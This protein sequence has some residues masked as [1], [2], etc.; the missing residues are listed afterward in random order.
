MAQSDKAIL[1]LGDDRYEFPLIVGSEGEKAIDISKLRARTGHVTLDPAFVNTA[2]CTSDITFLDGEQ[3]ILRYRGIPIE[4]LAEQ[5][6][7]TE[8]AYLLIYG[9]LPNHNELMAFRAQLSRHSMIHEGLKELIDRFPPGAHPMAILSSAVC[10]LSA[11][12]PELADMNQTAEEIELSMVRLIAKITT[13]AAY[14]YKQSIGHPLL[15][16][17]NSLGYCA[18]FLRMMFGV[19]CEPYE[20]D[21]ELVAAIRVL[22]ILHADH[23]QNCSTSTV[24]LVGSSRA[25]LFAAISAGILA[26]W[27]PLHGGANQAVL[28]MLEQIRAAGGD[29]KQFV[30]KAKDPDDS[31][32]L[33]GF[34][35]RVYKNYDPRAKIIKRTADTVLGKL[36]GDDELLDI[37]KELEAAALSDEYFVERKLY[38]NVDFYSGIIYHAMG[39]PTNMFTVMFAIG[40]LPGWIGQWKEML[41]QDSKIGRPRQI[42]TGATE[43]H[44]VPLDQR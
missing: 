42:Y 43:R 35:H 39:I 25:N 5:S 6:S 36:G 19:P 31:F 29:V 34:G 40:R 12:Y 18:N 30:A 9:D 8:T 20:V 32:R 26:L 28:E 22:L 21:P 24:R 27:G 15:Y 17:D 4:E 11:Y 33:M 23:E 13:I 14:A 10:A 2:A 44:F 38:P 3:G 7:F 41:E 16:P 37:A 1:E